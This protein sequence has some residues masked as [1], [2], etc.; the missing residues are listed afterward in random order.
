MANSGQD[1]WV[2]QSVIDINRLQSID[3]WLWSDI[4]WGIKSESSCLYWSAY[5]SRRL[6]ATCY[7][8]LLGGYGRLSI[9]RLVVGY[10]AGKDKKTTRIR[11][12]RKTLNSLQPWRTLLSSTIVPLLPLSFANHQ[13]FL[14]ITTASPTG[15]RWSE[16]NIRFPCVWQLYYMFKHIYINVPAFL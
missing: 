9:G 2:G 14:V 8:R 10:S 3:G 15:A 4:C 16:P 6:S 11:P 7:G 1:G 13:V 12:D 5:V